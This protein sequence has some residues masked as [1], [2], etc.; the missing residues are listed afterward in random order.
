MFTGVKNILY[1]CI[2]DLEGV[3]CF[4]IF[5]KGTFSYE[6]KSSR[7]GCIFFRC[8]S[9]SDSVCQVTFH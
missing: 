5:V 8:A 1:V 2:Y 7:F 4:S 3:S 9:F 6:H